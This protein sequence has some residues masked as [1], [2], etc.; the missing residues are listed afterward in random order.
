MDIPAPVK[1]PKLSLVVLAPKLKRTQILNTLRTELTNVFLSKVHAPADTSQQHDLVVFALSLIKSH[2]GRIQLT[3][4]EEVEM[5]IELVTIALPTLRNEVD[6]ARIK[7]FSS[8]A[9]EQGL[10]K[11][12][13]IVR[14]G[15]SLIS[16]LFKKK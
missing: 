1:N 12:V 4:E 3:Q 10:I 16:R 2:A 13:P 6:I 15:C 5:C 9:L 11:A 7:Q 14:V 8:F